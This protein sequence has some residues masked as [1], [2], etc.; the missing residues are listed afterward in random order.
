LHDRDGWQTKLFDDAHCHLMVQMMESWLIADGAALRKFYGQEYKENAIPKNPDVEQ[1]EKS[2]IMAAL[3]DAT[4]NTSKGEY[5]KTRH[6]FKILGQLEVSK[7]RN[8][9]PHC[10]RLFKILIEKMNG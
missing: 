8:A 3:K 9:A 1:L 7:I 4:R 10:D 2:V 6:G 5:H